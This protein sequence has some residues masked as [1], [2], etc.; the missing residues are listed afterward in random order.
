LRFIAAA[1]HV[2]LQLG[3]DDTA[4]TYELWD[5]ERPALASFVKFMNGD[6]GSSQ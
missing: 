2:A 4:P 1:G 6:M 5:D 3:A